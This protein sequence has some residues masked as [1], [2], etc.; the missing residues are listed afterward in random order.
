VGRERERDERRCQVGPATLAFLR[1]AP[2][3]FTH[4]ARHSSIP[5]R[6]PF[7]VKPLTTPHRLAPEPCTCG[8]SARGLAGPSERKAC[9]AAA[10][11]PPGWA[12]PPCSWPSRRPCSQVSFA[13]FM[14]KQRLTTCF[15]WVWGRGRW[16]ALRARP[17]SVCP[18][19]LSHPLF[20]GA[21]TRR[22]A[23]PP[24]AGP[25]IALSLSLSLTLPP[26]VRTY[27]PTHTPASA[28]RTLSQAFSGGLATYVLNPIGSRLPPGSI[29][30]NIPGLYSS[31]A[32]GALPFNTLIARI[33][34]QFAPGTPA[35]LVQNN[36]F[37]F[38][39]NPNGGPLGQ[40]LLW[41]GGNS[42]PISLPTLPT[43]TPPSG[44][45][46][47]AFRDPAVF[48]AQTSGAAPA[49]T[50]LPTGSFE[51]AAAASG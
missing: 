43:P 27:P 18:I 47:Y 2:Q 22:Q 33:L 29:N 45:A 34:P 10:R 36:P 14:D 40:Y 23:S 46:Q 44:A 4:A 1:L 13:R 20:S 3:H 16:E 24:R 12:W 25:W 32:T 6:P 51:N 7:A 11:R 5:P 42:R 31:P 17:S 41:W 35:Q 39:A 30:S 9:A 37:A 19:S 15:L 38:I 21:G 50:S 49:A 26:S 48:L 28:A 8:R